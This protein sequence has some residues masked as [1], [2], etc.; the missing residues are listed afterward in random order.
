MSPKDIIVDYDEKSGR[1]IINS[2]F[3][4][5]NLMRNI[6]NRRFDKAKNNAW[7]APAIRANVE[8]ISKSMPT[9]VT[10]TNAARIKLHDCMNPPLMKDE[11][12]PSRYKF[13]REPRPHQMN[14][15]HFGY[16]KQSVALF[17]DMRTGKT[18]VVIDRTMALFEDKKLDRAVIIPLRTLRKNWENAY[19]DDA[20]MAKVDL[21]HLDASKPKEF[22]KFDSRED[23][24]LKV[25]LVGIES[26]SAGKAIDLVLQFC[27]GQ[28]MAVVDESD[29]IKNHQSI[30]SENM[31]RVRDKC[32]YRVIM[33]GTP[34]SQGPIDFFAQFEFLNPDIFGVGD[35]YS[36]RN[37][38][39]VMGGFE[40]KEI[41]GHKNMDELTEL[42]KPYV[43]Q[44]Q[45]KDVFDSPP[46]VYETR[47]VPMTKEQ[48]G[49]YKRIKKDN[50]IRG[51]DGDIK[52]AVQNVLERMLR[53]H[54]ICGG[55]WAERIDTGKFKITEDKFGQIK[56]P[57]YKYDHHRI[58]GKMPK[59]EECI[60]ALTVDYKG[61]QGIVW[62]IHRDEL[63]VIAEELSKYGRVGMLHGGIPEEERNKLDKD[64]RAGKIDWIVA[65][66]T[67]GGRGYTFDAAYVMVNYTSSQNLI[68]RLQSLERATSGSKTRPVVIID[69]AVENSVDELYLE[70]L[71]NKQDVADF[72]RDQ[73]RNGKMRIDSLPF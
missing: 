44:V 29:T 69:L 27:R 54:E 34:I 51:T 46:A 56:K 58:E 48:T 33:T 20:D 53:L 35:F 61:E 30:R 40:D 4:A 50:T 43:Y 21:L 68:H 6:P 73:I 71:N 22:D 10:I 32:K 36:F 57:I 55:F 1:F 5:L 37:R 52:L 8:Y 70:S 63:D 15:L 41:I 65:N 66:P 9:G 28:A 38:Y 3:W 11:P 47:S 64:F 13:K 16:T 42:A 2:P 45:Y 12:F 23:G 7:T 17:M 39:A 60:K 67:T 25:L 19:H 24:R 26:L 59:V 49:Y 72:V 62:A 14:A 31:F 18:K